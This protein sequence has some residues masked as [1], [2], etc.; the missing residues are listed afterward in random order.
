MKLKKVLAVILCIV[1]V[2]SSLAL[3]AGA[4]G[5]AALSVKDGIEA[6]R[7][8]F[9]YGIGPETNGYAID[10]RYY[11]PAGENDDTKYPL[12]IWLH[13]MGDGAYEGKQL[14]TNNVANW[15]SAEFQ[16][17]FA[18]GGAYILAPRSVEE[19]ELYW[20][21][22]LLVPL[23]AAI[24][25]FIANNS[26]V[27]VSRIYIGG[28][29]MGGKMT[30]KMAVA[31]PDIFAAAFPICPAWVPDQAAA[32]KISDLPVWLVSS[33]AD[34]LVN[35][36]TWVMPTWKNIT[37][38]AGAPENCRFSTLSISLYPNG[39]PTSSNHHSWFAVNNDMFSDKN[40]DYPLMR[41]VDGNGDRVTFTYPEGMISWLCS[42][43]SNYDGSVAADEGNSEARGGNGMKT[44]LALIGEF[45]KNFFEYIFSCIKIF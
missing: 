13:G 16:S 31:Y 38:T 35:Y 24:D 26:N 33:A 2:V 8:Q 42:F 1:T 37:A 5:K 44:G 29:S 39:I 9:S 45:I 19:K 17:R 4:E 7:G 6:L 10:Y 41:T 21:D 32:E 28:Y 34:P 22:E 15:S 20:T 40:G 25:D 18:S 27:D 11:S 12:V 36:F 14:E 3:F 43:T 23:R 30:L